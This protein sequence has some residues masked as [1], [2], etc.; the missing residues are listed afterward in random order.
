MANDELVRKQVTLRCCACA[1]QVTFV[2][3]E[4]DDDRPTFFHTMPYC[5]R[6]DDVKTPDDVVSYFRDCGRSHHPKR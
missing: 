6:F 5:A 1:G 3:P 2:I 4:R